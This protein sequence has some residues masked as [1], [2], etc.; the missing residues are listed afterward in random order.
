MF[1]QSQLIQADG[2][3]SE[4]SPVSFGD[5]GTTVPC[6]G[7]FTAARSATS[8]KDSPPNGGRTHSRSCRLTICEAVSP[9]GATN[10]RMP[11]Q[12]PVQEAALEHPNPE[13]GC[14]SNFYR[15]PER[16]LQGLLSLPNYW[17]IVPCIGK[18][19]L[20]KRWQ[21]RYYSPQVLFRSLSQKGKV[22][23][24]G[25]RGLYSTVPNG[26]GLLCGRQNCTRYLIAIDC[27]SDEALRQFK[28]MRF[29]TTVSYSS[30]LPGRAQFL[31]YLDRPIKNFKL[32]NGL[33][34]RGKNL[35]STLPPSVHP[36][37]GNYQWLV[38]PNEVNIPTV[39]SLWIERLR[40]QSKVKPVSIAYSVK[41]KTAEELVRAINPVYADI[42]DDWI[43]VGMALK[44]W[45]EGL[46]WLWDDWSRNSS[47]HKPGECQYRWNT[48]NGFGITFRTLYYY[49][50]IG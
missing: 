43:R 6:L 25:N 35:L 2:T 16:L 22:W 7:G 29:P 27:D 15:S 24:M 18:Q 41:N 45:D 33:E 47:K 30:G 26:F 42:Y 14:Q 8:P 38:S 12:R 11:V 32:S 3:G 5:D 21:H 49:A 50:K 9:L 10:G 28:S 46:L 37:T 44:D 17:K 13:M 48:F 4:A 23:V 20:G 1:S 19:P 31:Y 36:K 39:S 34:I 40:P